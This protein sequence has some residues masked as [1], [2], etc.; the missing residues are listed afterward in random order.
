MSFKDHYSQ[1]DKLQSEIRTE[2]ISELDISRKTFYNRLNNDSWNKLERI[3][4]EKILDRHISR[5]TTKS[6]QHV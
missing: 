5:V 4:I 1:L 6:V 3:A 2:I